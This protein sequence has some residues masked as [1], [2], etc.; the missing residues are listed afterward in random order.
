MPSR[1]LPRHLSAASRFA[2]LATTLIG[3]AACGEASSC[4]DGTADCPCAADRFCDPGLSCVSGRCESPDP[5]SVADTSAQ[6]RDV[7]PEVIPPAERTSVTVTFDP[8]GGNLVGPATLVI[9]L[10]DP[11]GELPSVS[12]EGHEFTGW[13]NA[14]A[15]DPDGDLVT[16]ETLMT[17]LRDHTLYARWAPVPRYVEVPAGDVLLG[18]PGRF[19]DGVVSGEVGREYDELQA[20]AT[21]TRAFVIGDTEVTQWQWKKLSGGLNPSHFQGCDAC[22]VENITWWSALGYANA[23]SRAESRV[24]CYTIPSSR[25]DGTGCTGTWQAGSLDCGDTTP[26]VAAETVYDCAGYRLPTEAEWEYAARAGTETATYGGDLSAARG[27]VNLSG[28]GDIAPETPLAELGWYDCNNTPNGTKFTKQLKQNAWG[29]HDMLGNV[30]EWT[31]DRLGKDSKGPTGGAD[32]QYLE[33]GYTRVYR[34]GSWV[35]HAGFL[36]AANRMGLLAGG[37]GSYLGLRLVRTVAP[38]PPPPAE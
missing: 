37:R 32:P 9:F 10:R 11:Y 26:T 19:E 38:A 33:D 24:P 28:A 16:G 18:S 25:P 31:W 30:S 1:P 29:L 7:S 15:T 14:P 27:C 17:L 8:Q 3:L 21:L 34:G 4:P 5:A 35:K 6:I 12:R 2:A 20:D 36:R 22:P 23:L 13:F